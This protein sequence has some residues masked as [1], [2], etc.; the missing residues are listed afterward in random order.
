MEQFTPALH[1]LDRAASL[2]QLLFL[3]SRKLLL[4]PAGQ[5]RERLE[6]AERLKNEQEDILVTVLKPA[7]IDFI[8]ATRAQ[9]K[10]LVCIIG[11]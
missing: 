5:V 4:K 1:L 8:L 10:H 3:P 11:L 7:L 6:L 2:A 9:H